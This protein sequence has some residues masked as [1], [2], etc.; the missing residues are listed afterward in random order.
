MVAARPLHC[1]CTPAAEL[2]HAR[3]RATARP[4]QSY[5][6]P[7]AALL[8]ACLQRHCTPVCSATA[9]CVQHERHQ[10]SGRQTSATEE[11][12]EGFQVAFADG[13]DV[14]LLA[15]DAF[16]LL[17]HAA[18]LLGRGQQ[19]EDLFGQAVGIAVA[20]EEAV[21]SVGHQVALGTVA[22]GADHGQGVGHGVVDGQ[23]AHAGQ[24]VDGCLVHVSSQFLRVVN[25]ADEAHAATP[26]N[27][28]LFLAAEG[29][30]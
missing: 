6:T 23:S 10:P 16:R 21:S 3:C 5:C 24:H 1:Q 22:H 2:L 17:S 4:L 25:G 20:E 11:I 9:T 26:V 15:D 8:H 14:D 27:P 12:C 13:V 28:V 7:V 30:A 18:A 19:L 29:Q